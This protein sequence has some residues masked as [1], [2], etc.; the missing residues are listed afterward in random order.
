M[1]SPPGQA[2]LWL[3]IPVFVVGRAASRSVFINVFGRALIETPPRIGQGLLAQGTAS[4]AVALDLS[5]HHPDFAPMV[6]S[7]VLGGA[8][9]NEV[10]SHRALRAL[11]L[12]AGEGELSVQGS[13]KP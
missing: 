12:D 6:M 4:I 1:W 10:F 5:Q 11:L 8:L 9:V 13:G 3:L 7:T 2:A